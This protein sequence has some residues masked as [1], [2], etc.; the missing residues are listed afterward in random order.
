MFT[1]VVLFKLKENSKE[2]MSKARDLLLSMEGK[3]EQIRNLT[4]GEDVL[5]T[6]RSYDVCLIAT[7][8]NQEEMDKY[9]VH[10]YHVGT[11][12]KNLKP[13]LESSKACD[14]VS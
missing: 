5:F 10:E 9:Q 2:N 3:I 4:V 1:H 8:E 6:E 13:M 12:L 14:F 7:F 11:V